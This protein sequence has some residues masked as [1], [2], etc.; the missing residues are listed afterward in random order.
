[1]KSSDTPAAEFSFRAKVKKGETLPYR[2]IRRVYYGIGNFSI[3]IPRALAVILWKITS[4]PV[5]LY[6]RLKSTFW[7]TP[8]FR[9]ICCETGR[10]FRAGTF[11]PYVQGKGRIYIG[12]N[13]RFYGKQ[14]FLFA[15]IK[16]ELPEI[17]IG[18]DCVIGHNVTFDIA[19]KLTIGRKCMVASHVT[20]VD[21][22]GHSIVPEKRAAGIPPTEK[23]V[24]DIKIG[25]NVWIGTAAYVF[26]GTT[27][28]D[29][30][31][32]SA[33]TSVGRRIPPNFL[34][35][36]PPAKVIEIRNISN[37]I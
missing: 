35:Y 17:H 28:G 22:G 30:C 33:N 34:V 23:D 13:V 16:D 31:V 6:Y 1:M 10:N 3:W 5:D 25:D 36:A 7:V 2:I 24:R 9:G 14:Q 15:A 18:D 11:L 12:D 32:I 8:L 29:N 4:F 20:F 21:C 26:P 27:I 37:I 19:G